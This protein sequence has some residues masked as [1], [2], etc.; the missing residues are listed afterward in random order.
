MV[1][2]R[3]KRSSER[4]EALTLLLEYQRRSLGVQGLALE[5]SAGVELARSSRH[6]HPPN[7]PVATWELQVGDQQLV[8]RS[9]GGRFS[10]EVGEGVRRIAQTRA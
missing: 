3:T 4:L 5:T 2:R 6:G 9:I 10:H 1:E 8:I 7:A